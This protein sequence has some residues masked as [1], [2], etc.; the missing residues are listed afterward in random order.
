MKNRLFHILYISIAFF[1]CD[2]EDNLE[3][4]SDQYFLKYYGLEGNQQGVDFVVQEDGTYI[5]LGNSTITNGNTEVFLVKTDEL[6]NEIWSKTY[7]GNENDYAQTLTID[8]QGNLLIGATIEEQA[9]TF[10]DIMLLKVNQ[11]G[12]KIDSAVFGMPGRNETINDVFITRNNEIITTGSVVDPNTGRADVYTVKTDVDLVPVP[13]V[14]WKTA[15]GFP[16]DDFGIEI[17]EEAD[18]NIVFFNTSNT[19]DPLNSS[20]DGINFLVFKTDATGESVS[21]N[22]RFYGNNLNQFLSAKTVTSDGGFVL[23]GTTIQGTSANNLYFVRV[24]S[25][26]DLLVETSITTVSDVTAVD[27]VNTSNG[28]FL[29]SGNLRNG[30]NIDL[31]LMRTNAGGAI[32]WE[33][34]F[35]GVDGDLA[36]KVQ[37]L[38]DRAIALVGT[39]ELESQTKMCLIKTNSTGQLKP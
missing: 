37:E 34:A 22:R 4:F 2:T 30:N 26:F 36:A 33:Q 38:P 12:E 39:I 1:A 6:G 21:F 13:E 19:P 17:I 14:F 29:I 9:S 20:R 31:Y 5:L 18:G 16:E 15:Q 24:R 28:D 27:I 7:G 8:S 25:N 10:T 3:N 35:G 23:I 11:E 32:L